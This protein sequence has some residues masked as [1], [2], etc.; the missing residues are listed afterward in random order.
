[1]SFMINESVFSIYFCMFLVWALSAVLV[2]SL[3]H[4]SYLLRCLI[5]PPWKLLSL[6]RFVKL[7]FSRVE[8]SNNFSPHCAIGLFLSHFHM[9]GFVYMASSGNRETPSHQSG[10]PAVPQKEPLRPSDINIVSAQTKDTMQEYS[11]S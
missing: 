1:M 8:Q 2:L 4:W 7:E 9:Q 5:K 3:F 11:A 6:L 10:V